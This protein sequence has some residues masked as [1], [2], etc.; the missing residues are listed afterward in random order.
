MSKD[1]SQTLRN[2]RAYALQMKTVAADSVKTDPCPEFWTYAASLAARWADALSGDSLDWRVLGALREEA[3]TERNRAGIW[4]F[5]FCN[6]IESTYQ[7]LRESS[8]MINDLDKLLFRRSELHQ[9]NDIAGAI[10]LQKEILRHLEETGRLTRDLINAHNYLSVLYTKNGDYGL[11]EVHARCALDL[12]P[13]SLTPPDHDA[14]ACYSMMLARILILLGRQ[15]EA[16][17][18]AETALKEWTLVH[19][20][21]SDFLDARME[22]LKSIRAGTWKNCFL[23]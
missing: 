3:Q 17:P 21:P 5:G 20:P 6:C 23:Y 12:A 18:H 7:S 2:A 9:R 22:E 15:S 19:S 16:I 8:F 4:L 10:L 14:L 1:F 13:A 11:A